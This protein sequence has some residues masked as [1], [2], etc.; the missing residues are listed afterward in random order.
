VPNGPPIGLN[1]RPGGEECGMAQERRDHSATDQ[2]LAAG[3]VGGPAGFDEQGESL[4]ERGLGSAP[5]PANPLSADAGMASSDDAMPA[6]AAEPVESAVAR[7][8]REEAGDEGGE[9]SG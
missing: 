5:T 9:A 2:D 7:R 6:P 3:T 8:A 1:G 4:D